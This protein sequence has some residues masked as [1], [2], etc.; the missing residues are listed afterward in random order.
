MTNTGSVEEGCTQ[1]ISAY[2]LQ[3]IRAQL[4][5]CARVHFWIVAWNADVL[6]QVLLKQMLAYW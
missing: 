2:E 4:N 3:M 6:L 1:G 5:T